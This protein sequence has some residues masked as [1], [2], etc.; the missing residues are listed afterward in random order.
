MPPTDDD[1]RAIQAIADAHDAAMLRTFLASADAM[2]IAIAEG[3]E[4]AW[5][6]AGRVVLEAGWTPEVTAMLQSA[7]LA[8]QP[9]IA[10][11]VA[12]PFQVALSVLFN[13]VNDAAV[14][15]ARTLTGQRITAIN[16]TTLQG[17]RTVLERAF[18][19][20]RTPD[21]TARALAHMVGLTPRQVTQLV[22][23]QHG[24]EDTGVPFARQ[25]VLMRSRARRLLRQRG[26]AI[27]R[28]ETMQAAHA[29][30]HNLWE[31]S[32]A[33]GFIPSDMKRYWIVTF[34]DRLCTT[35]CRRIPGMNSEGRGIAE[36]FDT[37]AGPVLHAPAHVM[38]RCSQSLR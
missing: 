2:R 9:G 11:L 28:T 12:A 10:A 38:C 37:P 4:T 26:E 1:W 29:G 35:I 21:Q 5:L 6:D 32:Q 3:V 27:A 13:Q 30:Q 22:H 34:D 15:V 14:Q 31:A 36:P 23:F 8:T 19:E 24:L 18:S 16:E 33:Q 7:A 20:G 17:V 25:E